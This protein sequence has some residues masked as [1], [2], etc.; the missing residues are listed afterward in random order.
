MTPNAE[1]WAEA[2]AIERRYG[3]CASAHIAR[4]IEALAMSGDTAGVDRWREIAERYD[5]L[6]DQ[7]V[8]N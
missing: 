1:R 7:R 3:D 4:R 8:A 2:L 5:R 6:R